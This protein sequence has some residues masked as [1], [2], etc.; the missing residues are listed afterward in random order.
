MAKWG[1][2]PK[3]GNRVVYFWLVVLALLGLVMAWEKFNG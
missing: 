2:E 1:D 3:L